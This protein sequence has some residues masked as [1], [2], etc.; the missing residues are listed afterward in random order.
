MEKKQ[1]ENLTNIVEK[2][3]TAMLKSV[4]STE[5]R[6]D[7]QHRKWQL[8]N[9]RILK[10]EFGYAFPTTFEAFNVMKEGLNGFSYSHSF[11]KE[12]KKLIV[13]L[14]EEDIVNVRQAYT[15]LV[16]TGRN[17]YNELNDYP[18]GKDKDLEEYS[19][20]VEIEEEEIK[21]IKR[22][23][24][25]IVKLFKRNTLTPETAFLV[26][27]VAKKNK[28]EMQENMAVVEAIKN[29]GSQQDPTKID[30]HNTPEVEK[31]ADKPMNVDELLEQIQEK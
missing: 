10:N 7:A 12:E 22:S 26:Y 6:K 2:F 30:L 31:Y 25:P 4:K 16:E 27:C 13:R 3:E 14:M 11:T 19:K 18:G 17:S 9:W 24:N 28:R 23:N 5:H 1:I 21:V 29:P 15:R 20:L 8:D